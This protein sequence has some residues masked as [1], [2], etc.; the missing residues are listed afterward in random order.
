MVN[1]T[2]PPAA[3]PKGM[4]Q[5][6]EVKKALQSEAM[7]KEFEM[8]LPPQMAPEKFLRVAI[9]AVN[10]NPDLL[11]ADRAGL[12]GAFMLAA[13]DGLLPDGREGAIVMY[14][15]KPQWM[16]MVG[17]LLKKIR[18]SG[19]LKSI[20]AQEIYKNDKFRY[21][22]DDAGEHIEHDPELFIER[23]EL[24]GVYA[25]AK[26]K[27]D[28]VYVEVMPKEQI[29]KVRSISKAKDGPAWKN[30]YD[31]MAKKTVIRRL[32]KR[33]PMSTDA[34]ELLRREDELYDVEAKVV[35][36]ET[37]PAGPARLSK[38][39][40]EQPVIEMPAEE[41]RATDETSDEAKS[42]KESA[43]KK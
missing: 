22:I 38:M 35:G 34:E 1:Q 39:L 10:K 33:L 21:W 12:Y 7:K 29:D 6:E 16:P 4:T 23:G 15:D 36:A 31:Q 43:P 18:N 13:Q 9:T 24:L 25:L 42:A 27:D 14:G 26:T 8:A 2:P 37:K 3:Q 5:F 40:S 20:T 41:P 32:S 17:G 30:W 28:G 19:E 11:R